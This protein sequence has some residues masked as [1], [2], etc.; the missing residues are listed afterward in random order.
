M[1]LICTRAPPHR[2][3]LG[4]RLFNP[5]PASPRGPAGRPCL[6]AAVLVYRC[7][8][9]LSNVVSI[10]VPREFK[11]KM[12]RYNIDWGSEIRRFVEERIRTLELLE[13]LD[14]VGE[15]ARRRGDLLRLWGLL[16]VYP[17][18]S[19]VYV[20]VALSTGSALASFDERL[21]RAAARL[22]VAV[23]P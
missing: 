17:S 19:L 16:R 22:G 9:G 21:S 11:E 4:R 13:T 12:R 8:Y 14:A 6:R 15:R 23:H 18:S 10:R 3:A 5:P 7:V 2:A 1:G 20:Q